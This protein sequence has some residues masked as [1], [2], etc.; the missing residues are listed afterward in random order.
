MNFSNFD[1]DKQLSN[2]KAK[3]QHYISAIE[4]LKE[5]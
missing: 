1:Q 4:E 3:E 2:M 5:K